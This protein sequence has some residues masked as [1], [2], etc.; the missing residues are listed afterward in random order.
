MPKPLICEKISRYIK[1]TETEKNG[2]V[3]NTLV[4]LWNV[5]QFQAYQSDYYIVIIAFIYI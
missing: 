1:S 5:H 3:N 4:L 2:T